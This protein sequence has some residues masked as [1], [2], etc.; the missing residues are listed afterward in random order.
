MPAKSEAQR[1]FIFGVKGAKFARAHHFD[2]PGKLPE[3]VGK[4]VNYGTEKTTLPKFAG[5][6]KAKK[7]GKGHGKHKGQPMHGNGP[8]P[9]TMGK[10][11]HDGYAGCKQFGMC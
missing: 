6:K 3:R 5:K 9:H 8:H 1:R 11:A 4:K 7:G 10:P 2:N